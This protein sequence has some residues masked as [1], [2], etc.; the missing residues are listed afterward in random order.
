M[1]VPVHKRVFS[2]IGLARRTLPGKPRPVA[3]IGLA[4]GGLVLLLVGAV[5]WLIHLAA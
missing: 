5:Y 2:P 4:A 3:G 1:I